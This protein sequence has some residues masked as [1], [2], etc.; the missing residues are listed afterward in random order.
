MSLLLDALKRAEQEKLSRNP[1][2]P[3]LGEAPRAANSA[4]SLELQPVTPPPSPPY[5]RGDAAAAQ[6]IFTAKA[7]PRGELPA[8]AKNRGALWAIAG[9][10]A[11]VVIAAGGYVWYS[12]KLLAPKP[13]PAAYRPR[14]PAAPTPPPATSEPSSASKMEALLQPGANP[15]LPLPAPLPPPVAAK[16]APPAPRAPAPVSPEQAAVLNLL[17]DA[18]PAAPAE[19]PRL[20]RTPEATRIP[21]EVSAGYAALRGGDLDNARRRY[22]AAVM[23]EPTNLDAHLGLAT[24]E[25]RSG[26]RGAAATH[27]RKALELD[28]GNPTALAGMAALA[29]GSRPEALEAQLRADAAR[30]PQSAALQFTLG[31]L[32]IGQSRWREAQSAFFEAHRL[33]PANPD[34]LYN[35]AVSLDHLNQG[36]LAA[37]YYARALEE[38]R[39]QPTQF[40]PAPVRRRLSELRP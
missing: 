4:S 10:I 26:N 16:A 8:A 23:A 33:D 22:A 24:A 5:G 15:A 28:P 17:K 38:S 37:E 18:P 13:I 36:R 27:Y 39:G 20:A 14:P 1:G 40:D 2:E 34:I 35:L 7:P 31:N 11:I 19:A 6:A 12:I 29:G 32:Y 30:S 21:A 9:A 25:A 3:G